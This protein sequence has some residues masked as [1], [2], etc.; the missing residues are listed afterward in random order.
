MSQLHI[1]KASELCGNSYLF[2]EVCPAAE[3]YAPPSFASPMASSTAGR[4]WRTLR[5]LRLSQVMYR[6]LHRSMH[7]NNIRDLPAAVVVLRPQNEP[8]KMAEWHPELARQ[9][10]RAGNVLFV[11]PDETP[12]S[13]ASWSAEEVARRQIFH[14]NYCDFLNA[15]LTS[16]EDTD[17]LVKA[18]NI[19]L[20]W[21]D[22]NPTGREFAW[23]PF[24]LSIR[25][26]N[27]LK[28]LLRNEA[29][30]RSLGEGAQVDEVLSNLRL[31]V[32]SLEAR[33]ERELL[34]NHL[35]KN[36][37]ALVFAGTLLETPEA[38]RWRAVGRDILKEQIAEQILPDGGH[39]ER[40]PMYHAWVLDDMLDIK[41]LFA[42]YPQD[43]RECVLSV[44]D[45]VA[46]MAR[47]LSTIVHPDGEIPLL[48]DS[49]MD[50]TRPTQ[51]ILSEAAVASDP[52]G[53]HLGTELQILADTGYA[54]IR[55]HDSRSFLIFDC[56]PLGPDYQPGHGH[57]D[58]LTYELAL[59]GQRVIVDT[60]VS[61]YEPSP[62]RQYERSTAGH[63]TVRIDGVD[64][65]EVWASFRVG[66]RPRVSRLAQ[67]EIDGG[68]FV[69]GGH[70]GYK[71][72]GVNHS[73]AICRLTNNSWIFAD[74]IQGRG[75]HLIESF[76][77]FHPSVQ[78]SPY[79]ED[80]IHVS[81]AMVP[82]YCF[83]VCGAPYVLFTRGAGVMALTSAWYAPG[84]AIR[85]SQ[86]VVHWSYRGA[87]PVSLAYAIAP[88]GTPITQLELAADQLILQLSNHRFTCPTG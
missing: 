9:V 32:L 65:A 16:P 87:L 52:R 33:L 44:D 43:D 15:D 54:V 46:R 4:Y 69:R 17:I 7:R 19:A 55:D 84:F 79:P 62:E 60:G 50:V 73:R 63:N 74:S 70:S 38:A 22:L 72:L 27:W 24:S 83:Q 68:A 67:G 13:A 30:A 49:Q 2:P 1:D 3:V 82:R 64:Q 20:S 81:V 28:F 40:S 36:A 21:R 47:Y 41:Q 86:A 58:V 10:I 37:K 45:S 88:E 35:L 26:V 61:S 77:H 48:N 85:M 80:G 59:H 75:R 31:Q 5:H 51:Q 11:P 53:P 6:A 76:I 8:L 14:A 71:R 42:S 78:I 57:S 56:G 23:Q 12:G 34:A 29:K 66:S 25:I 39:I 18:L